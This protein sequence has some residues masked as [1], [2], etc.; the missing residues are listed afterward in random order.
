MMTTV[1]DKTSL[2][3]TQPDWCCA[4]CGE[5]FGSWWKTGTYRGPEPHIATWSVGHCDVCS[6]AEVA[7]TEARD[8]GYLVA[9]WQAAPRVN[10]R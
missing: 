9:G 1:D 3:K 6:A 7:V 8:F 5:T 2:A 4:A 10:N